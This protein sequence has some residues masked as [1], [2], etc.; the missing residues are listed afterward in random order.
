MTIIEFFD[1]TPVEN[2][3]SCLSMRPKR[4]ILAGGSGDLS[5]HARILKRIAA[6]HDLD[7]EVSCVSI[8]RSSLSNAVSGLCSIIESEQDDFSIDLTG[9]EDLLLVAAGIVAERYA[10]HGGRHIELHHY[11][12]QTGAVQDC[13]NNNKVFNNVRPQLSIVDDIVLHGGKLRY[14]SSVFGDGTYKLSLSEDFVEDVGAM[15]NLCRQD[16]AQWNTDVN[17]LELLSH[18]KMQEEDPLSF[19]LTF[20]YAEEHVPNCRE[21]LRRACRLA[22]DLASVGVLEKLRV[23]SGLLAFRYKNAQIKR[24]LAKAGSVLETKMLL[25]ASAM[26]D[27]NGEPYYN[28]AASGV[29]I[30]WN[31]K[32]NTNTRWNFSDWETGYDDI[33]TENEI[34]VML[35]HGAVPV[36]V[37]C[38]NGAVDSNELYKL[39]TVADRFGSTYAKKVIVATYL[40]KNGSGREMDPFRRRAEE[41]D[42]M[43][44][45][46]AHLMSDAELAACLKSVTE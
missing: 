11:N 8:D 44:I 18:H 41:M 29:V 10:E 20:R 24:C 2:I 25:L 14:S 9:G 5:E 27:E 7:I 15:W 13:D 38:K 36:F 19:F 3:I 16:P 40:G 1:R 12:V 35:M 22:E 45:E 30:V 32:S 31:G 39:N 37:S 17:A 26:R 42:I 21:K 28:D 6:A 33:S 4:V 46:E 34:D 23:E 43:L